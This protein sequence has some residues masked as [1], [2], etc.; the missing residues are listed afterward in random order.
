M[1][2]GAKAVCGKALGLSPVALEALKGLA[3]HI[4]EE[5]WTPA[6]IQKI[7]GKS[8]DQWWM[9]YQASACCRG[10]TRTCCR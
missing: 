8:A 9:E 7:S 6:E 3:E 1:S 5:H 10:S 4:G 2:A